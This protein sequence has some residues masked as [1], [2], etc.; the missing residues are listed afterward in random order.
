M[1]R[2]R[3]LPA[4]A[5]LALG[6]GPAFAHTGA[7][8]HAGF[9]SGFL[10]PI[11]GPDHLLAMLA[12]GIV[13]ALIGGPALWRVP[14]A[15]VSAMVLG[16]VIGMAGY[17]PP[18]MELAIV[19]SVILLGSLIAAGPA[20]PAAAA[21]ASAAFFG[22]F[23]GAAHGLEMPG[24]GSALGYGLG[25][26]SATSLLH[27]AGVLTCLG[28]VRWLAGSGRAVVRGGGALIAGAGL[29]LMMS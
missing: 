16:G 21:F 8:A 18:A 9:V 28:I 19:G 23:H 4:L 26:A 10:H 29:F 3:I 12:V 1:T 6:A 11:L 24:D 2:S 25:F 27:V 20:V 14:A 13:S 22:L 5:L 17:E 15:F 7:D